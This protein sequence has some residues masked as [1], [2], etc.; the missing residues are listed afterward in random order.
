VTARL[1]ARL[2]GAFLVLL[3]VAAGVFVLLQLAPGDAAAM[4]AP[5]DA[6]AA[7]IAQ[8]RVQWGLDQPLL[9]RFGF[10]LLHLL[11][12]DLGLSLRYQLP[13]AGLIAQRL[14]ATLELALAALCLALLVGIPLGVF[15]A[16]HKGRAGDAV[17]S[18]LAVSGVSA[19]SFWVGILL[20]L[21][22]SAQLRWL[23]S[24]G[25]LS[26][27]TVLP[28]VTGLHVLD[29]VLQGRWAALRDS[30]AHLALPATTLALGMLGIVA[31]V[32]RSALMGVGQQ[33]F[34]VTAVAKGLSRRAVLWRHMLPNAA[35]QI[36]TII[37]LE[38][39]VLLSSTVVVEVVFSW[40][41][42]GML[43][44]QAVTVR[45]TPL[46]TGVVLVYAALFIVL[47][48]LIDVGYVLIDPR[49]RRG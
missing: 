14:P 27:D 23:P 45:D 17:A 22:F 25:R 24:S 44:Y 31:R 46:T 6:T 12:F 32:T 35:I 18:V 5:E 49:L 28:E 8:L 37:G 19:P 48:L 16:L 34:V 13:V 36:T 2:G 42:L 40:P 29:S 30:L 15:A 38:L 33:E 4:L 11:H 21:L 20:V 43:L 26:V 39:G 1:T 3:L 10:F 47:N 41:G 7:D 9:P